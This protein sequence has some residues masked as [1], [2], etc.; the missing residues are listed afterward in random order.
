MAVPADDLFIRWKKKSAFFDVSSVKK[1]SSFRPTPP[2]GCFGKIS[3]DLHF[4]LSQSARSSVDRRVV[5][6]RSIAV[7]SS[8][9][10][11]T[12]RPVLARNRIP[13]KIFD[14]DSS[15]YYIQVVIKA[16][17]GPKTTSVSH[18]GRRTTQQNLRIDN[19]SNQIKS[20]QIKSEQSWSLLLLRFP[21]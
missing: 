18:T 14:F 7:L 16:I 17:V 13:S 21:C 20:N 5:G 15:C 2:S 9:A 8:Y 11:A 3:S 1:I 12:T 6:L 10:V 4:F 19:N